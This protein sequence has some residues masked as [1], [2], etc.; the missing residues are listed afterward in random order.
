M[1]LAPGVLS[2]PGSASASA[3]GELSVPGFLRDPKTELGP[4]IQ[5]VPVQASGLEIQW[6]PEIQTAPEFL[7]RPALG[8]AFL[9][10]PRP[11]QGRECLTV[12]M[13]EFH[14]G[15]LPALKEASD[16]EDLADPG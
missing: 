2:V 8:P 4:E 12:P 14:P 15:S 1:A 6:A 3:R 7:P 11:E 9:P 13:P 16:R 10:D 5:T